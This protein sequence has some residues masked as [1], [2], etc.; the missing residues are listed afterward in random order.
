ME[1]HA[2]HQPNQI[3]PIAECLKPLSL[4]PPSVTVKM[5]ELSGC[6]ILWFKYILKS[7]RTKSDKTKKKT[8]IEA[9]CDDYFRIF[10]QAL[11]ER[12]AILICLNLPSC[13]SPR[14]SCDTDCFAQSVKHII[15][16]LFNSF[17]EAKSKLRWYWCVDGHICLKPAPKKRKKKERNG[18]ATKSSSKEQSYG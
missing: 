15:E 16:H 10:S 7:H 3:V 17:I 9:G 4:M 13:R 12:T 6:I 2:L 8:F 5:T 11:G 14:N 1:Q 18:N